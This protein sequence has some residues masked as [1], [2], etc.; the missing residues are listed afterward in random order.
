MTVLSGGISAK[1]WRYASVVKDVV[2]A[3]PCVH[4]CLFTTFPSSSLYFSSNCLIAL[5]ILDFC[6]LFNFGGL[7]F[8]G[9]TSTTLM[10]PN[11]GD[12]FFISTEWPARPLAIQ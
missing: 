4:A 9:F 6:H 11:W 8:M 2:L 10:P 1:I 3:G 7:F 5:P 12:C